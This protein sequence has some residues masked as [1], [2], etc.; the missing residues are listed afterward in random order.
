MAHN[1]R[2]E[3]MLYGRGFRILEEAVEGVPDE[4]D[5]NDEVVLEGRFSF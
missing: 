1:L 3:I 2:A 5:D 4:L